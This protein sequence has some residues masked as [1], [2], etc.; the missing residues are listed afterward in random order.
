[1]STWSFYDPTTGA[2]AD[3][4]WGEDRY[5]AANTPAGHFALN[6]VLDP[7]SQR[8]R[9]V[10]DDF[11]DQQPVVI[12]WQ[13]EPPPADE[14]NT[15]T[16]N[17]DSR[18]YQA[19]ATLASLKATA[20]LSIDRHAGAARSRSLTDLPG[21]ELIYRRK[22]EQAAMFLSPDYLGFA[23]P[24][25]AAEAAAIGTDHASA[26]AHILQCAQHFDNEVGPAIEAVRLSAK[27]AVSAAGDPEAVAS[28]QA[29]AEAAL[30]EL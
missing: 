17:S 28:L 9:L 18:R 21:Q 15:W 13:P 12:D 19:V 8:V 6:L 5:V 2:I 29:A 14:F 10:T 20:L 23:P 7:Y 1:M 30:R 3:H 22:A 24:Y 25:V 16:W 26:A 4:L 27:Y 11:G